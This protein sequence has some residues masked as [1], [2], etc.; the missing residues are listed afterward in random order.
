MGIGDV[1]VNRAWSISTL[2]LIIREDS[3]SSFDFQNLHESPLGCFLKGVFSDLPLCQRWLCVESM[4]VVIGV[5]VWTY[6]FNLRVTVSSPMLGSRWNVNLINLSNKN[7]ESEIGVNTW[8]IR[9]SKEL[10]PLYLFCSSAQMAPDP[11]STVL[12]NSMIS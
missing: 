9:K 11:F 1:L 3:V 12:Q 10:V 4:C 6:S 5:A 7:H 2:D 8:M